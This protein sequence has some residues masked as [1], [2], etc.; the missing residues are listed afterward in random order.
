YGAV[1]LPASVDVYAAAVL[2]ASLRRRCAELGERIG[3][4]AESASLAELVRVVGAEVVAVYELRN[5]RA[6]VLAGLG[7]PVQE[8]AA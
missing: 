8:V 4:V 2:D 7:M 3:Q 1:P 6:T 5:R